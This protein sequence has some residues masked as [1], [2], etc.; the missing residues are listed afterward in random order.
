[1]PTKFR[2]RISGTAER[3]VEEIWRFIS[4]DSLE[5]ATAFVLHLEERVSTLETFPARCPLIPEN[6]LIGALYRHLIYG[7]YRM[8]FRIAG[9][10]VYVLRVIHSARL[11]DATT[12]EKE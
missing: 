10:I 1:M 12:L 3:D 8:I 5:A 9:R 2:V 11:L 4:Q 7:E 6:E